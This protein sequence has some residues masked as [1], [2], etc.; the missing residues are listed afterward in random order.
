MNEDDGDDD[1]DGVDAAATET[2]GRR[3]VSLEEVWRG[4]GK[5]RYRYRHRHALVV[6]DLL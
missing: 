2:I 6:D 5:Y 3:V 1:D 4:L